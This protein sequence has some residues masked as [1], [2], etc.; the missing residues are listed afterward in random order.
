VYGFAQATIL[1]G[2]F[3]VNDG[4]FVGDKGYGAYLARC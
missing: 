2:R 4:A 1:R 3:V